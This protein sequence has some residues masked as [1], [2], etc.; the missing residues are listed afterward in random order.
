YGKGNAC[1]LG[2]RRKTE[3]GE[4]ERHLYQ[5]LL[6]VIM[7]VVERAVALHRHG[8][9]TLPATVASTHPLPPWYARSLV[10]TGVRHRSEHRCGDEG[11]VNRRRR[12]L[13]RA[14][15]LGRRNGGAHRL[16]ARATPRPRH[17]HGSAA[18]S[19]NDKHG[20]RFPDSIATHDASMDGGARRPGYG[21]LVL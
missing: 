6:I 12:R 19:E 9:M 14:R 4:R 5:P 13:D 2:R 20:G 17:Q 18:R 21:K 1:A 11:D 15:R 16:D 7:N 3:V 10:A 8:G